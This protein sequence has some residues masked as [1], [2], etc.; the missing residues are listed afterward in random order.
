MTEPD[1]PPPATDDGDAPGRSSR[2]DFLRAGGFAAAGLLAGGAIAGAAG[3][4]IGHAAGYREGAGDSGRLEP[5]REPGF[6][7]VVVLMGENRSM[8]NLLGW[9]Y[10]PEDVP[11]GQTF[12]GLAFGSYSNRGPDGRTV[13]AHVYTGATDAIMRSPDPDPGE[14]YPYVNTQLFG[15]VD[16]PENALRSRARCSRRTTRRR[17]APGPP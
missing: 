1:E 6:D 14:E 7:H 17:R 12:D 8:D 10:T 5:R 16:P 2:R 3:A 13:P 4:V 11:R 9:L 15:R